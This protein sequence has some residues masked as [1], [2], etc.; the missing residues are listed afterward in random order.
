MNMSEFSRRRRKAIKR[1]GKRLLRRTGDYFNDQSLIGPGPVF[2]NSIFPWI[3]RFERNW[4]GIRKELEGVLL[5]RSA[6][7]AFHEISPDQYRISKGDDWKVLPLY[8]F[9]R[10]I[11]KN[12][13]RCPQTAHLLM[14]V[15]HLEN[16]MFSILAPHFKIPPHRGLTNGIV[17]IHLGLIVPDE[18]DAC[19]IRVGDQ[20]FGWEEGKCVVFDD[21]YE[22]E[23]WNDTDQE[24]VVLFFD[25]DRPMKFSGRV[26]NRLL[27]NAV[28]RSGY[29]MDPVKNANE[30]YLP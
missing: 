24:R 15:P 13:S 26:L 1:V 10:A 9:G 14:N 18:K 12:C 20:I 22:H 19:Q 21:F 27:I 28:K 16:A 30:F 25:V 5:E 6:L 17:R 8:I 7:P 4:E 2:D 3:D 29:G 23:V 11:E